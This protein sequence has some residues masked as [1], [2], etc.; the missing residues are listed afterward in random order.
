MSRSFLRPLVNEPTT[1][2]VIRNVRNQ[3]LVADALVAAFDSKTR[4]TGLLQHEAFP[5]GSAMLIAPTNAVHTFFMRFSIDIA[6]VT[7]EGRVVKTCAS[8]RP[9][10]HRGLVKSGA[11][12]S[13]APSASWHRWHRCLYTARAS[14]RAPQSFLIWDF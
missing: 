7:R 14:A 1:K 6:F 5:D 4:R 13:P 3:R 10:C 12:P 8:V 2:F 9:R 11:S